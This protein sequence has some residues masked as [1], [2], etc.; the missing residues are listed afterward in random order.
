MLGAAVSLL[1]ACAASGGAPAPGNAAEQ[2]LAD[3]LTGG[4]RQ[5]VTRSM[6]TLR[7]PYGE[8]R[9]GADVPRL[10][11]A[12]LFP[13][14]LQELEHPELRRLAARF[15]ASGLAAAAGRRLLPR[16]WSGGAPPTGGI[17]P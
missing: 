8:V 13:D 6:M 17:R 12:R 5:L 16:R 9:L 14:V 3:R 15:D 1:P 7:L 11:N 2:Q 10:P 4:W